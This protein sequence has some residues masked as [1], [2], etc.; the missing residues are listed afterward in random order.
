MHLTSGASLESEPP[1]LYKKNTTPKRKHSYTVLERGCIP[2]I[3]TPITSTIPKWVFQTS[4]VKCEI[5]S[6]CIHSEPNPKYAAK[7]MF[8]HQPNNFSSKKHNTS[9]KESPASRKKLQSLPQQIEKGGICRQ[10]TYRTR[11]VHF[12]WISKKALDI[13]LYSRKIMHQK[14]KTVEASDEYPKPQL[15]WDTWTR[16]MNNR[17]RI[18]CV[19]N[20]TISQFSFS[21]SRMRTPLS[22]LRCKG[23]AFSETD[24]R[25]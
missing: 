23:S 3:P 2:Y 15:C 25:I 11:G 12:R 17:T 22:E 1:T 18:C 6:L 20:Y 13:G 14:Q 7:I 21:N 9:D 10:Q 16:T 8:F 24:K 4:S 5:I 19:A